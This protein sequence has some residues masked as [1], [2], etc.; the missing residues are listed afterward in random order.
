MKLIDSHTHLFDEQFN[1]DRSEVVSRAVAAGVKRMVLPAVDSG[2][3]EALIGMVEAYPEQVFAMMGLHPTSVN[4]NPAWREELAIV[5]RYL[6]DPPVRFYAVG[7]I[8]LDLYWSKDFL[9][10]QEEALRFQIELALKHD[11]PVV[12]HNRE[13]F[14]DTIR[15]FSDYTSRGIRGIFHSFSGTAE[16]YRVMCGL[17]DFKFGIG[18]VAT[19]KKSQ[20]AAVVADM[21]LDDIVLETDSP[22]LTPV[23]FRG[24]RNESAYLVYVAEK[25]AE[26]KGI[27]VEEVARTT[28]RNA[29]AVF[30]L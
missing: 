30:G 21:E 13:A 18:G 22:Y 3:H 5:E 29:E 25:I 27:P 6:S 17:G 26:I 28:T 11:L 15:V 16:Q 19:Y 4:D 12:V 10:E 9:T 1:A 2:S 8:G 24:K 7:E 23:P 20:V 14:D